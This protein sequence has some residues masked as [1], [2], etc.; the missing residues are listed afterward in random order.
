MT[1]FAVALFPLICIWRNRSQ[2]GAV[3]TGTA[4]HIDEL[5]GCSPHSLL[6]GRVGRSEVM[7]CTASFTYALHGIIRICIA[8]HHSHLYF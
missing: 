2:I 5:C 3:S 8:L 6:L 1:T 7:H 4:T